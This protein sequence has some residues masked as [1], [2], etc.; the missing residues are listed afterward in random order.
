MEGDYVILR[1]GPVHVYGKIIRMTR[2]FGKPLWITVDW[3]N[4]KLS[5]SIDAFDLK[6]IDP[7]TL[8]AM[9]A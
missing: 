7:L 6:R 1:Q 2:S 9:Q 8:L 3:C 5:P 4:G